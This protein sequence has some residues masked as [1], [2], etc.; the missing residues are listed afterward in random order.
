M[1]ADAVSI[2]LKLGAVLHLTCMLSRQDQ[3]QFSA[4]LTPYLLELRKVG[5]KY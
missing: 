2:E 3:T 4:P 1:H 5:T